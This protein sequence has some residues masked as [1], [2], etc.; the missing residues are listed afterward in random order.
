MSPEYCRPPSPMTGTPAG[1]QARDGLV[2]RGDLRDAD[3]GHDAGGA[4][5]AR[6][7]AD[8]DGVGPGVDEG[9]GAGAGGDVAADDLHVPGG[10]VLLDPLDHLEQE[11]GV[12]VRGVDDEHV[13][14]GLDER[15]GAL[16]R[17]AEVADRGTDE[18][19]AVGVLAGVGELLGLH[20]VLDGDEPAQ[21]ALGVDDRQPLA[22]V[23]A[24]QRGGLVV[25]DA[26]LPGDERHRGHD[27][28]RPACGPLRDRGEAQVAVGDD[29]EEVVALV[30]DGQAR[31]AVAAADLV[32]LLESGVG[33][34]G[35]RVGDHAGLGALDE[36]DLVRLVLDRQ[37][38]VQD[39]DAAVPG[40][41]DG[42]PGLGDGVHGR[43]DERDAR[44]LAGQPGRRVDLARDD[45]GLARLEQHVVVGEPQLGEEVGGRLGGIGRTHT[46]LVIYGRPPAGPDAATPDASPS[47]A[48]P[49][50][51]RRAGCSRARRM[52]VRRRCSRWSVDGGAGRAR[53]CRGRWSCRPSR[54]PRGL[55][56]RPGC[57]L[58][59]AGAP[60]IDSASSAASVLAVA[61]RVTRA[62]SLPVAGAARRLRRWRAAR[63]RPAVARPVAG[64][65]WPDRRSAAVGLAVGRA[66]GRG[67]ARG[68]ASA[69]AS[70]S[71]RDAAS[72]GCAAWSS[73]WCSPWSSAGSGVCPGRGRSA[74]GLDL[75]A[76]LRPAGPLLLR[77]QLRLLRGCPSGEG[78]HQQAGGRESRRLADPRPS[79][80]RRAGHRARAADG[81]PRPTLDG[82]PARN[83]M[84]Q[85]LQRRREVGPGVRH[86]GAWSERHGASSTAAATVGAGDGDAEGGEHGDAAV[87]ADPTRRVTRGTGCRP[88]GDSE[89]HGP[90]S[91]ST[92]RRAPT[93]SMS[94]SSAS[95]PLSGSA[96]RRHPRGLGEQLA[97]PREA[98]VL[99]D[100]D[101][102]GRQPSAA[103]VSSVDIPTATRRV[104]ISCCC[105]G[106]RADEG[107]RPARLV[108]DQS[109]LLGSGG[110]LDAVGTSATA[111]ARGSAGAARRRPCGP[112]WRR[113]RHRTGAAVVVGAQASVNGH[114][115]LLRHVLGDVLGS[116]TSEPRPRVPQRQLPYASQKS[117]GRITALASGENGEVEQ[118]RWR[119]HGC[120]RRSGPRCHRSVPIVDKDWRR[121][122]PS[123][124]G[125]GRRVDGPRRAHGAAAV[126]DPQ[127]LPDASVQRSNDA[128]SLGP[129]R[130]G[131]RT[132][133]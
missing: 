113:R 34:D 19:A 27:V 17:L 83:G 49:P 13:D 15:R 33:A 11:A 35:D 108:T 42:H 80:R 54:R 129:V 72:T 118:R 97:Q 63:S 38:A 89:Q 5:R 24:Q 65:R 48:A 50:A 112:R 25:A 85:G 73:A 104:R 87:R 79:R 59:L 110:E 70:A 120:H 109:E 58:P 64:V 23:L 124:A 16:P 77:V 127:A 102:A 47:D 41:G 96:S 107:H 2:D 29:A 36:V 91:S 125:A 44:D 9:L 22:L 76:L 10:G 93:R 3:A 61:D 95:I 105:V 55:R 40:H 81:I 26:D 106:R 116:E 69:T 45:V 39:A 20:E 43:R 82:L 90:S 122:S 67:R 8:L 74:L 62:S 60:R 71:A 32:E 7:D 84:T 75:L 101:G 86:P 92:S 103:T 57:A 133:L 53:R 14:P 28:A 78:L 6:P 52:L 115:H 31:D 131:W 21:A 119:V 66:A 94:R 132:R 114:T 68:S 99:G 100:P 130:A 121:P 56:S 88:A 46:H 12:A 117:L 30:D 4:D 128:A 37:V 126:T 111:S 98:P 1:P 51:R 123:G 18:E